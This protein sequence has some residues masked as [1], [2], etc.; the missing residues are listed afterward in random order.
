[1]LRVAPV[2][3]L[4]AFELYAFIDCLTTDEHRT[5]NLPKLAWVFIILLVPLFGAVGW[6]VAGRPGRDPAEAARTRFVA[7]DDDPEFLA[8]LSKSN[9]EH[10]DMLKRWEDD[11]K[12]REGELRGDDP[13]A[14]PRP[15]D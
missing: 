15:K 4:F 12:R 10:E 14:D 7:P 2:L 13:D 9:K 1:M 3:L 11:L 5:R 6:F 8:S